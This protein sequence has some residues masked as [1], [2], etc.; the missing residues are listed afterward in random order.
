M[1]LGKN[2]L[3]LLAIALMLSPFAATATAEETRI[4]FWYFGIHGCLELPEEA[5]PG[6]MITCY[7]R[8]TADDVIHVNY[9]EL[10]IRFGDIMLYGETIISDRDMFPG[11]KVVRIIELTLPTE[12]TS[13]RLY[14]C[15]AAE[16][17]KHPHTV[18]SSNSL[19]ATYVRERT[20]DELLRDYDALR[21]DYDRLISDYDSLRTDYIELNSKYESL[22]ADYRELILKHGASKRE[23]AT[24]KSMMYIFMVT[25][26]VFIATTVYFAR[27]KPKTT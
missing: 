16:T 6:E 11:E 25:T 4:E 19:Y 5:H 21:A 18:I 7:L 9:V 14:I 3:I 10:I 12:P 24:A 1:L 15:I 22:K 13:G 2:I 26:V 20:Y 8:I 27:R 17:Y 23:L